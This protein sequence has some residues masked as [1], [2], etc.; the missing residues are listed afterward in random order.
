MQENSKSPKNHFFRTKQIQ[1]HQK[2]LFSKTFGDFLNFLPGQAADSSFAICNE[3]HRKGSALTVKLLL[4]S[5]IHEVLFLVSPFKTL[6][7]LT[8]KSGMGV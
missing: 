6:F 7:S 1:N 8:G 4:L 2:M 5:H 3:S